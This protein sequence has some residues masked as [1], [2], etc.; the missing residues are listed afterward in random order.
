ME[1]FVSGAEQF[2]FDSPAII[3]FDKSCSLGGQCAARRKS[4][5]LRDK[6]KD[7]APAMGRTKRDFRHVSVEHTEVDQCL[8]KYIPCAKEKIIRFLA[9]ADHKTSDA[10][11][12]SSAFVMLGHF[13]GE[14][15]EKYNMSCFRLAFQGIRT[16]VMANAADVCDFM[17]A[18]GEGTPK[19]LRDAALFI[20]GASAAKLSELAAF[21][22]IYHGSVG[23]FETL[24]VPYG[25]AVV[26]SVCGD[27]DVLGVRLTFLVPSMKP[28]VEKA[29]HSFDLMGALET[30]VQD[31]KVDLHLG[32]MPS[33]E[34]MPGASRKRM[35][36]KGPAG[37]WRGSTPQALLKLKTQ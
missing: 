35:V 11:F 8:A 3:A 17:M 4:E 23:P 24:F 12:C 9:N 14:G 1:P 30:T 6:L 15:T 5:A 29:K 2:G 20:K 32:C 27:I 13:Y 34:V 22:R 7:E 10:L 28:S 21:T 18:K 36:T 25:F 26:E 33:G 31:S 16:V 19:S 37:P